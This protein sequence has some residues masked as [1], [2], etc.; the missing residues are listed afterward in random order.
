MNYDILCKEIL[1]IDPNERFAVAFREGERLGGGYRDN[2]SSLL[3]PEEV[4]TSLSYAC[5]RWETRKNLAHRI[6]K[7]K[8]SITEYEKVKQITMPVDEKTL[9]L[10]SLETNVDHFRV[11]EI[12]LNLKKIIL[13]IESDVTK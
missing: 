3:S 10:V 5:Q 13:Q 1:A 8:I 4:N 6:G 9:L 11:V 2:V 7:A 12:L